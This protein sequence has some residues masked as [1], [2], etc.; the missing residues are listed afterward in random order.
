MAEFVGLA[1][2]FLGSVAAGAVIGA[3][4]SLLVLYAKWALEDLFG[5]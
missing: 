5:L 1:L 3:G 2:I 4:I